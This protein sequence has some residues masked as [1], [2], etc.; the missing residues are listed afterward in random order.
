MI[1]LYMISHDILKYVH[2]NR[3]T[4]I[5]FAALSIYIVLFFFLTPHYAYIDWTYAIMNNYPDLTIIIG[6]L[7]S[8]GGKP[9]LFYIFYTLWT[10]KI[11]KEKTVN[12]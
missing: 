7:L 11:E 12:V 4:M 8:I 5:G 3:K 1:V 10:P 2:F 6:F 9:I